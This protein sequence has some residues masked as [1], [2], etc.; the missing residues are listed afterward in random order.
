MAIVDDL[1]QGA[2]AALSAGAS[3]VRGQGAALTADFENLVRP[4][5]DAILIQVAAITE[6]VVAGNIGTDQARDD[7]VTQLDRVQP[8]IL[9]VAELA[10][11][12]VQTIINAV[13]DALK[14]VVNAATTH[15]IGVGLL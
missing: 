11:L 1:R 15:A 4:N 12:A 7:L 14:T 8:L 3:A 13:L 5:L 2:T 9:A 6:D 10:L